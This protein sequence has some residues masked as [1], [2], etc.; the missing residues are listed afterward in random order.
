ML[1]SEFVQ[2]HAQLH[3]P[4]RGPILLLRQ[5]LLVFQEEDGTA[6]VL[7]VRQELFVEFYANVRERGVAWPPHTG[8]KL[9]VGVV[10]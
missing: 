6:L 8:L 10:D 7:L 1:L 5:V 2:P 4:V 3:F 9:Q